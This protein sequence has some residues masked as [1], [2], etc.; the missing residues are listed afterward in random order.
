MLK[1]F[2][3]HAYSWYAV[4]RMKCLHGWTTKINQFHF[5]DMWVFHLIL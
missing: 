5:T 4:L 3:P 2:Q 1:L